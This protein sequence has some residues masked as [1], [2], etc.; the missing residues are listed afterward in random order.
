MR[1]STCVNLCDS[2]SIAFVVRLVVKIRDGFSNQL[3]IHGDDS[4]SVRRV[5]KVHADHL[6]L[7][8]GL[9]FACPPAPFS[10]VNLLSRMMTVARASSRTEA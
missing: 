1:H 8:T 3:A 6:R 10:D 5:A 4:G 2:R 9:F 7:P